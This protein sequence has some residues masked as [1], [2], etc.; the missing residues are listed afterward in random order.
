[1]DKHITVTVPYGKKIAYTLFVNGSPVDIPHIEKN[2]DYVSFK[3]KK[4]DIF[5]LFYTFVDFRRAYIVTGYNSKLKTSISL[6]G[7]N[8]KLSLLYVAKGR[9]IDH[10]KRAIYLLTQNDKYKIYYFPAI[11]WYKLAGLIQFC[12]AKKSDV[13]YL[14]EQFQ[15]TKKR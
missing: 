6:P 12:G 1:M 4:K 7:I 14:Y 15:N 10:L 9:K 13:L 3:F 8:E 11:F 5:V 2:G